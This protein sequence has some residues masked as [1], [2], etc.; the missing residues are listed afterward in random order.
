MMFGCIK[1]LLKKL[2]PQVEKSEVTIEEPEELV[3]TI[4]PN[5]LYIWD[6][7]DRH[8]LTENLTTLEF[9]CTCDS[10]RC[11]LQQVSVELVEK[12]EKI[13]LETDTPFIITSGYRCLYHQ[14]VLR[15]RGLKTAKG[16]SQHSL[17]HAVDI[18][19]MIGKDGTDY[20]KRQAT[21]LVKL[22]GHFKAIGIAS[23][24]YHV[25]LRSDKTRL[26]TY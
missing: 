10:P 9:E 17:G 19:P 3:K 15:S 4:G 25:D 7:G 11:V 6:R 16:I 14:E 26:W 22:R 13:K 8:E 1:K 12:L 21:F 18:K 24:W 20:K 2:V 5:P 23:G